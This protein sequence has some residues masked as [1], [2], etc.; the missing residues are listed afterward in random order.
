MNEVGLHTLGDGGGLQVQVTDLGATW[1]SC[2]LRLRD[3]RWR[4]LL[5]AVPQPADVLHEP[6]FLGGT[7]GRVANRIAGAAFTLDGQRHRLA[8][9]EGANQLHGGPDGFHRRRWQVREASAS[10]LVMTL[11][12]PDGDQGY[13]GS[14]ELELTWTVPAP[15]QLRIAWAARCDA[16][17]PVNL[18]QHAY[19]NLDGQP[20]PVRAHR[21]TLAASR[22]AAVDEAMI[23]TGELLEVAGTRFDHRTG[24]PLI[25][26]GSP[27]LDTAFLLDDA[28]ASGK[29]PAAELRSSDGQVRLALTTD[30]PSLQVYTGQALAATRGRDG[31]RLPAQSGVALE[32]QYL[33]DA[34][35]HPA[36]PGP[37]CV[38]RPGAV[39]RH[40]VDYHFLAA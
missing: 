28:A 14:L 35:H 38:L 7:V 29:A 15:G 19:F 6:G 39:M 8:A 1:R 33:P 36:W 25:A 37:S 13:P 34:V 27:G 3:G 10:A 16:P 18:T 20:G 24:A 17:C 23:P 22:R 30:L 5:L 40:H 11:I 26:A 4:E 32:P 31:R 9:N 12:S 21:L 2:R